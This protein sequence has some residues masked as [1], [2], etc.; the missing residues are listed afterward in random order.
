MD[1]WIECQFAMYHNGR[2]YIGDENDLKDIEKLKKLANNRRKITHKRTR[3]DSTID[4]WSVHDVKK[5][6]IAKENNLNWIEFFNMNAFD[7][8]LSSYS[9]FL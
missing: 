1:L 3:Y 9:S 5:R 2:P 6:N 4:I 7:E 8:W